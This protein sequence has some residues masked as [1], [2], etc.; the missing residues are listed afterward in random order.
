MVVYCSLKFGCY[1]L[2]KSGNNTIKAIP[3]DIGLVTFSLLVCYCQCLLVSQPIKVVFCSLF[4]KI[5]L[6]MF[7]A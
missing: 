1:S 3:R 7:V 2:Y 4:E 6:L 5:K